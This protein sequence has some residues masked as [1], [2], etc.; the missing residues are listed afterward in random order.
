MSASSASNLH[1]RDT[2]RGGRDLARLLALPVAWSGRDPAGIAQGLLDELVPMLRADLAWVRLTDRGG[3][4]TE[5]A[6][7][8]D[9]RVRELVRRV[10]EQPLGEPGLRTIPGLRVACV[11][12]GPE[13]GGGVIAL[14]SGRPD[15]PTEAEE[16]LLHVA[17]SQA[18]VGLEAALLVE[19]C[20]RAA[21]DGELLHRVSDLLNRAAHLEDVFGPALDGIQEAVRTDRVAIRLVDDVGETRLVAWRGL[22]DDELRA[23]DDGSAARPGGGPV[24]RTEIDERLG[25]VACLP[26]VYGDRVL[27]ELVVG[28]DAPRRF[29]EREVHLA[30]ALACDVAQAVGRRQAEV[31]NASLVADLQRNLHFSE[32]FVGVLGHDLRNPLFAIKAAAWLLSRRVSPEVVVDAAKRISESANRMSRMIDQILDFTRL[33]LGGE[34]PLVRERVDLDEVVRGVADELHTVDGT[35]DLSVSTVG[36]TCGEW[37]RDRLAQMLSN[38]LGNAYQHATPGTGI[39]LAIDGTGAGGVTVEIRSSGTIDPER[40][41]DLF[42]PL[43]ARTRQRNRGSS[44]L[45]L[46]LYICR[47][48]ALAHGGSIRAESEGGTTRFVV[49][50]PRR[51]PA[52]EERTA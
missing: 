48:I 7:A 15:F 10:D 12:I 34:I 41:T 8:P 9:D 16:L 4:R 36:W 38:L 29:E 5:L 33:R 30:A 44:G 50:L 17:A 6:S 42:E 46:G 14:A 40:L 25:S 23:L 2:E 22:S 28:F 27:G 39:E 19:R 35:R 32:L 13:G 26:L 21:R 3:P 18:W 49:H 24:I 1:N 11:P 43:R 45:G 47:Q 52:P 51:T 31:E 20:A 37:D